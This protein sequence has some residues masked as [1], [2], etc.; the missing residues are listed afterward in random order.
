MFGL[1]IWELLIIFGIILLLFGSA[2]LPSLMRNIGRS[3]VEF[4]KG[5]QSDDERGDANPRID[6]AE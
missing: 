6:K 4:K 3:A 2:K 1:H 5:M